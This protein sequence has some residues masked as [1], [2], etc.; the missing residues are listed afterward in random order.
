MSKATRHRGD[1]FHVVSLVDKQRVNEVSIEGMWDIFI[2]RRNYALPRSHNILTNHSTHEFR[3]AITTRACTLT[4]PWLVQAIF[5][6]NRLTRV[7]IIKFSG[8]RCSR[9]LRYSEI[10]MSSSWSKSLNKYLECKK[11]GTSRSSRCKVSSSR[12]NCKKCQNSKHLST[13]Y[14][15]R[16]YIGW[17][18]TKLQPAPHN[19][20]RCRPAATTRTC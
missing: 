5:L 7:I 16:G 19:K 6:K 13:N 17:T 9:I 11:R 4:H 10:C 15:P 20:I 12:N 3:F 14:N 1:L 2:R 18:G 8:D